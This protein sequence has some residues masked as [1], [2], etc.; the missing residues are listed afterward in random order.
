[1]FCLLQVQNLNQAY[2]VMSLPLDRAVG[3]K[4]LRTDAHTEIQ[5]FFL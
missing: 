2:T 3:K 1:M 4:Y 5:Y